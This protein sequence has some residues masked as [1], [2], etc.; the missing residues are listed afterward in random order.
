MVCLP[1][2]PCAKGYSTARFTLI[3]NQWKADGSLCQSNAATTV[4][5][6][7]YYYIHHHYVPLNKPNFA[8]RTD[9]GCIPRF[10]AYVKINRISGDLGAVQGMAVGLNDSNTAT[11]KHSSAMSHAFVVPYK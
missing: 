3:V 9:S 4:T 5:K 1:K 11:T 2:K 6:S 7:M 10:N 8:I